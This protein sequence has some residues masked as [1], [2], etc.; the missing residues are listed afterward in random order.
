M[1]TAFRDENYLTLRSQ[2]CAQ[3]AF[4]VSE[5]CVDETVDDFGL[6]FLVLRGEDDAECEALLVEAE[7]DAF[8]DVEEFDLCDVLA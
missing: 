5:N 7:L 3:L 2:C 4:E 1:E 6:E 8:V